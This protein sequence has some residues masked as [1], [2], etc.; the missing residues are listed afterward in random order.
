MYSL[1]DQFFTRSTLTENK[2]GGGSLG[3]IIY[4]IVD[5]LHPGVF[6]HYAGELVALFEF[7][8]QQS[9]FLFSTFEACNVSQVFH[10]SDDFAIL[11]FHYPRVFKKRH[12]APV[13]GADC[14]FMVFHHAFFIQSA[15]PDAINAV[16]SYTVVALKDIAVFSNDILSRKTGDSFRSFIPEGDGSIQINGKKP[17]GHCVAY[18]FQG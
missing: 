14:A 15:T 13:F 3:N 6:A 10:A 5:V 4:Q 17:I 8:P 9:D 2:N 11:V 7:S 1:R 16:G 12:K 18:R